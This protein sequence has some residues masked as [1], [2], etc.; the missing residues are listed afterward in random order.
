MNL[1]IALA[2][3]LL[4]AVALP[5]PGLAKP[6]GCRGT[7][8]GSVKAKFLCTARV[9]SKDDTVYFTIDP[10]GPLEGVPGYA[11]GSFELPGKV[12]PR[13]WT[14]DDLGMGR[15][16]V[17]HTNGTLYTAQKTS[18]QRGE[19]KLTLRSLTPDPRAKGTW[20]PRGSYRARLLP[21]GEGKQGEVTVEAEF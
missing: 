1:R 18:S 20:V 17:A 7:L 8:S 16:S 4:G 10:A 5:S 6:K 14:L 9:F 19:V 21:A 12:E 13:T 15:A 11:P 3:L 2:A